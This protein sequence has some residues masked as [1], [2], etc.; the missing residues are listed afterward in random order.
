MLGDKQTQQAW[1]RFAEEQMIPHDHE[2][3]DVYKRGFVAGRDS[4]QWKDVAE[5][6]PE[7]EGRYT[8]RYKFPMGDDQVEEAVELFEPNE[9]EEYWHDYVLAYIPHPIPPYEKE[10]NEREDTDA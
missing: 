1:M 6:L 5:G 8:V 7:V 4:L 2:D 3:E 9:C 10:Q